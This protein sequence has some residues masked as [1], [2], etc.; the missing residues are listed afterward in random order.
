MDYAESAIDIALLDPVPP[1][2]GLPLVNPQLSPFAQPPPAYEHPPSYASVV[3]HPVGMTTVPAQAN[4]QADAGTLCRIRKAK[5]IASPL[6]AP[7]VHGC[8]SQSPVVCDLAIFH[9]MDGLQFTAARFCLRCPRILLFDAA[10]SSRAAFLPLT[11]FLLISTLHPFPIDPSLHTAHSAPRRRPVSFAT[12]PS[13]A[14]TDCAP[15]NINYTTP[16]TSMPT[17]SELYSRPF[18]PSTRRDGVVDAVVVDER[19]AYITRALLLRLPPPPARLQAHRP[20]PT[21]DSSASRRADGAHCRFEGVRGQVINVAILMDFNASPPPSTQHRCLLRAHP[22]LHICIHSIPTHI[23][24][25]VAWTDVQVEIPLRTLSFLCCGLQQHHAAVPR[26]LAVAYWLRISDAVVSAVVQSRSA[27]AAAA[28]GRESSP[29]LLRLTATKTTQVGLR[30]CCRNLL[31]VVPPPPSDANL[32]AAATQPPR[33]SRHELISSGCSGSPVT[34]LE[35]FA[36]SLAHAPTDHTDC[37]N[38]IPNS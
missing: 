20:V 27:S 3:G 24:I 13:L 6:D 28:G 4:Q 16:S 1:Y 17:S 7:S 5:Q 15:G 9:G 14:P 23:G 8:S 21:G 22:T 33:E 2:P 32:R 12:R 37:G 34:H 31:I 29:R 19:W 25:A 38:D 26:E 18:R 30:V 35:D 10:P 11:H 36:V